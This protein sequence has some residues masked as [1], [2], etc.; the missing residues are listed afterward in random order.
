MYKKNKFIYILRQIWLEINRTWSLDQGNIQISKNIKYKLKK[1]KLLKN[2]K[3][4]GK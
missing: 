3:K 1:I 4:I 2:I